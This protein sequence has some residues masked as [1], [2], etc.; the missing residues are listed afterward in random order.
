MKRRILSLLLALLLLPVIGGQAAERTPTAHGIDVSHHQGAIDWDLVATQIDFAI[1]RIGY[2]ANLTTQ[3]D[4][5]WKANADAC[6]RLKIPFG[7]YIYSHATNEEQ[8]LDEARHVLRQIKGYKLSMPVYLDLEDEDISNNCSPEQILRNATVFCNAIEAAGYEVGIY[9]NTH[10][11]E[12]YLSSPQYD[13]WDRW[14]ARYASQTGYNKTYSMWQYT[15]K[16]SV[17]GITGDV[18]MNYWYAEP[19]KAECSHQ[20]TFHVSKEPTCTEKGERSY[21][22]S[23]C[24]NSYQEVIKA[25]GHSYKAQTVAPTCTEGGY[26]Q[27]SCHCGDSY[28][29]EEKAPRGHLWDEGTVLTEPTVGV[30]GQ[31]RYTCTACQLTMTVTIP[32]TE[33]PCAGN[34]PS[35]RFEDLPSYGHWAHE[36]IDFALEHK[37][38]QGMSDTHFAPNSPMTRA[39]L[40]TVLWRYAGSP[41]GGENSFSDVPDGQWYT[42]AV[43]WANGEEIVAGVG[44]GRF[45]PMAN[46]TREQFAAVLYRF[47]KSRGM[48]PEAVPEPVSFP[49][50][51][52]VRAYA[53]E[54]LA[55][56]VN[57]GLISGVQSQG[58][59]YLRPQE[60]ATR[61]QTATILYRW[62]EGMTNTEEK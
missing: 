60:S 8:A 58:L 25:T 48:E 46:I 41:E 29:G 27:Y 3:D 56:A 61:A 28:V 30:A 24:G 21:V 23:L 44:H 1:V 39:M 20:Y 15:S 40:V 17:K 9:A 12:K 26:T 49:D 52:Q 57:T 55:W 11:W 36:G 14:V 54:P 18:D 10:W 19:P 37:L 4:R 34:C 5:Y 16:G 62:I 35:A 50:W 59:S 7:V 53:R 38:F 33:P 43:T 51:E 32:A 45:E 2:G 47:C 31:M 22:C 6:T 42:Q 13:K